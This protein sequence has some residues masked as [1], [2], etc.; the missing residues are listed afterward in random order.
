MHRETSLNFYCSLLGVPKIL[1]QKLMT[2][3]CVPFNSG[4][5]KDLAY[6]SDAPIFA[7]SNT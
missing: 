5:Q 7:V 3:F 6:L 2:V 4:P 1:F